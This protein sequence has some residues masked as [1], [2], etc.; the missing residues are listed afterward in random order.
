MIR[1]PVVIPGIGGEVVDGEEASVV[2]FRSPGGEGGGEVEFSGLLSVK[3]GDF[4]L[5]LGA[6]PEAH[7]VCRGSSKERSFSD[8]DGSRSRILGEGLPAEVEAENKRGRQK[9]FHKEAMK[10]EGE[11]CFW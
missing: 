1:D 10:E 4:A 6:N 8:A 5:S 3:D 2:M 9:E 7:G 11:P